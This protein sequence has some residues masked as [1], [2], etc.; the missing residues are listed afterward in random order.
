[1]LKNIS[2]RVCG[3]I[4]RICGDQTTHLQPDTT[5]PPPENPAA[6]AARPST[7]PVKMRRTLGALAPRKKTPVAPLLDPSRSA[8]G[9]S[10]ILQPSPL[11]DPLSSTSVHVATEATSVPPDDGPQFSH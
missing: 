8:G 4:G 10:T 11:G 9:P 2:N 5:A 3:S 1:M 7:I 6:S